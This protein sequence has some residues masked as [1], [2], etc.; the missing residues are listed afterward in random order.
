MIRYSLDSILSDPKN[1]KFGGKCRKYFG[2][3]FMN[4]VYEFLAGS[5]NI[6]AMISASK[7]DNPALAGVINELEKLYDNKLS[8]FKE[9]QDNERN[10]DSIDES[11]LK[12]PLDHFKQFVGMLIKEILL[13]Y[14]YIDSGSQKSIPKSKNSKFD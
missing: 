2:D 4:D 1:K 3:D 12:K 14:G 13:P 10:T 9:I 11:E 8:K 7:N 6:D 5:A